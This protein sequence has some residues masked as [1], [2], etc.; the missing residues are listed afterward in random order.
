MY[1]VL[2]AVILIVYHF[3][4]RVALK[5]WYFFKPTLAEFWHSFVISLVVYWENYGRRQRVVL[6]HFEGA[7]SQGVAY[8]DRQSKPTIDFVKLLYKT[9]YPR[10]A[11][12]VEP[13][14][15]VLFRFLR[16]SYRAVNRP[17]DRFVAYY[18]WYCRQNG[19]YV[20]E[21]NLRARWLTDGW[22]YILFTGT[23][24]YGICLLIIY[25]WTRM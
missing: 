15:L 7:L 19:I 21:E 22:M 24:I 17:F 16:W 18:I 12:Y 14:I 4:V 13:C 9:H 10:F 20:E 23:V 1:A 8:W 5:V 25:L 3:S 11:P 6:D 2:E